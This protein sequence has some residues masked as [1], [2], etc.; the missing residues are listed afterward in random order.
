MLLLVIT[1]VDSLPRM[2][3]KKRQVN[4]KAIISFD[5]GYHC[6]SYTVPYHKEMLHLSC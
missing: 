5:W 6:S 1:S 2:S 3:P 4:W